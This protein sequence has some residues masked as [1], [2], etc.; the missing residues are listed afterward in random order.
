[1]LDTAIKIKCIGFSVTGYGD[2]SY[3]KSIESHLNSASFNCSVSYS[4]VGG[5]SI[6]ALPYLL[7]H[8]IKDGE[9]DLVILE[10]ATSW[11][12][13]IRKNI[14]EAMQ[15]LQLIIDYCESIKTRIVFLNLYRKDL[16]DNDIVVQAIKILA[17][18]RHHIIDLKSFFRSKLENEANDG[19]IDG[20]HPNSESI[21]TIGKL[22]ASF[23][24]TNYK[25][26][27]TYQTKTWA[28]EKCKLIPLPTSNLNSYLFSTRHGLH[29]SAA[30]LPRGQE[31]C[32]D[33]NEKTNISGIFFLY[34]PD[35][36]YINLHLGHEVINVAMKD[37]MSF[38][39]RLGYQHFGMREVA[40]LKIIHPE[41]SLDIKL[42]QAPWERNLHSLTNYIIGFTSGI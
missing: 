7:R 30:K 27:R 23:V 8:L 24:E 42:N 32:L 15:Y 25:N 20:V 39:R 40:S 28:E 6:D 31:L 33:L 35:T 41:D 5:L 13:L 3:P 26:F 37:S 36:N 2:P 1:M 19:T 38:Y 10:L 11:F 29:I 12:S 17:E 14:E 16:N 4:S 9:S 34:G 21:D 18:N 22:V